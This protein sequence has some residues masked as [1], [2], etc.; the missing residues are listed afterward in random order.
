M[1][2]EKQN[3]FM[4]LEYCTCDLGKLIDTK[5]VIMNEDD[6]KYIF[7]QILLGLK[8]LHD[9]WVMHRVSQIF[10]ENYFRT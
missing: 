4:A 5:E 7:Y 6:V 8:H 3:N 1:F 10:V 9:N 2:S